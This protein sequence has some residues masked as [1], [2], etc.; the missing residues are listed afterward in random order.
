MTAAGQVYLQMRRVRRFIKGS[1]FTRRS[2]RQDDWHD[3]CII[4]NLHADL[5]VDRYDAGHLNEH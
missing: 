1:G 3:K 5:I 4:G 2:S